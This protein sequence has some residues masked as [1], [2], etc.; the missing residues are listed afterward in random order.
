MNDSVDAVDLFRPDA[1]RPGRPSGDA[2]PSVD[3]TARSIDVS[4]ENG[5]E[6]ATRKKRPDQLLANKPGSTRDDDPDHEDMSEASFL[7]Q[8]KETPARGC[9]I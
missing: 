3:T 6:I 4:R 5:H 1:R 2:C 7:K 9:A 8:V